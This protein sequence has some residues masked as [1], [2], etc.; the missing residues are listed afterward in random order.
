MAAYIAGGGL[1]LWLTAKF[2]LPIG[3]PFLFG[4]GVSRLAEPLTTL[5]TRKVRFPRGLAAFVSVS[6]LVVALSALVWLLGKTLLSELGRFARQLPDAV[7][8]LEAPIEK[9]H[10]S[11]L[12]LTQRLPQGMALAAADWLESF[13]AGSSVLADSV[14]QWLLRFVTGTLASVPDAILFLLTT[15][16]SAY[17]IAA[18]L[19]TLLSALR[20]LLPQSWR[21][22]C[23]SLWNRL[24]GA[25]KGYFK[26]Q[27]RL[28]G[29]TFA[30]V[31][32]GLLLLRRDY[33]LLIAL[34][35]ALVDALP[36]FGA[37][38]ILV[39]WGLLSFLR[40]DSFVGVGLLLVYAAASLT[41]TV[42]E[43]RFL[44]RQI[45]LDPLLTLLSLYAG[46]RLFGFL[47]MILLPIGVML[48]KQLY[49]LV[50]STPPQEGDISPRRSID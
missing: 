3:L 50:D 9:L 6:V 14:S 44:G 4:L 34:G 19:P 49:D 27:I 29:V 42:L 41:R 7:S 47:G 8:G 21:S 31:L 48:C 45:G 33:A 17:L 38:T 15:L 5:L 30:I 23:L 13:F 25:L 37:G 39:P 35:I 22:R 36:V 32:A 26:A 20:R 46:Y 16:L 18:E 12:R 1:A 28:M 40:G 2:L 24:K 10:N 43:P 11:L